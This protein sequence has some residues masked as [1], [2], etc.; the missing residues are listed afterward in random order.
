MKILIEESVVRQALEALQIAVGYALECEPDAPFHTGELAIT[1]LRT[2][3]DNPTPPTNTSD[4]ELRE[5]ARAVISWFDNYGVVEPEELDRL[6]K[7]L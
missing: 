7:A 1:A 6:R 3:L 4:S 5:A 2:A